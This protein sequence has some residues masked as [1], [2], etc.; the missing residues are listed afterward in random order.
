MDKDRGSLTGRGRATDHDCMA[1]PPLITSRQNERVKDAVR[2]RTGRERGRQQRFIIDG[3]REISRALAAGI[4]GLLAFICEPLCE[5][6]GGQSVLAELRTASV[7]VQPVT[8]EVY[9]K[10]CFGDREDD[11][12]V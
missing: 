12:I 3:S 9:A 6:D 7:E 4:H 11:A 2:L 8:P 1:I 5:S 10:L